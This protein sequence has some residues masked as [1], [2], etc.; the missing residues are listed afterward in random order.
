MFLYEAKKEKKICEDEF[1]Q[2]LEVRDSLENAQK[3]EIKKV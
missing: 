3:L 2:S 1:V